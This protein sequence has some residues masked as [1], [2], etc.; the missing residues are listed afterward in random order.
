MRLSSVFRHVL[1]QTDREFV[2]LAEEFSFLRNYLDI[3]QERFG[4]NLQVSFELEP[5]VAHVSIPTLLLQPLVE[6]AMKH[7]LAPKAG[8][9][10]PPHCRR[11]LNGWRPAGGD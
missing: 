4:E 2:T 7:G 6:N 5:S 11:W 10:K 3:E 9:A 8:E 1:A